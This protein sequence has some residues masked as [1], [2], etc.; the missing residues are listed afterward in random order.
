MRC[1]ECGY[2][3]RNGEII[4][5]ESDGAVICP[6]CVESERAQHEAAR[7]EYQRGIDRACGIWD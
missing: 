2:T 6:G 5:E 7:K 4:D 3:W 1:K